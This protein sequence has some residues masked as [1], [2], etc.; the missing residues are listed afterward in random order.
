MRKAISLTFVFLCLFT[1]IQALRLHSESPMTF[2][3]NHIDE[4]EKGLTILETE[5]EITFDGDRVSFHGCNTYN[6]DIDIDYDT[7][8]Y[9]LGLMT[10]TLMFCQHMHDDEIY[11]ALQ[12]G[13]QIIIEG[14]LLKIY[15][16]EGE[17]LLTGTRVETEDND[18][19]MDGTDIVI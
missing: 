19:N 17:L 14:R 15:N 10:N 3:I 18:E 5:A 9:T 1:G 6:G 16:E 2:R 13:N 7:G 11:N 8:A 4:K 12:D